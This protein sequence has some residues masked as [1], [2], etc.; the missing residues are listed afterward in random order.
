MRTLL[1]FLL[2]SAGLSL[3]AQRAQQ[4]VETLYQKFPQEKVVLSLSKNDYVAG[5]TIL[6]KAY[7]LTGYEPSDI[8]T[9]L[10]TELYDS[11]K[12]VI[13]KQ[14]IPLVKG[15]GEGS[16]VLP[17]SLAEDVYY[18]R[19]YTHYM[20]NFSEDFHYLKPLHIYNPVSLYKLTPKPAQWTA[21]AFAEGGILLNDVPGAVAIRLFST[22]GLPESWEGN[23]LEKESNTV[24]APIEFLNN[25]VGIVRFI[26]SRTKTYVA[27]IKDN[28]GNTQVVPI[29]NA[30]DN[31]TML[32]L[33]VTDTKIVYAIQTKNVAAKGAGYQLIGTMHDQ[34]IFS[35]LIKK[36][37]GDVSGEI[38]IAKL[39]SGVLRVT[40]FNEQEKPLNERLCFLHQQIKLQ[41]PTIATDTLSFQ[42]KGHNYWQIATDSISWLS[43]AVQISD[44]SYPVTNNFLSDLYLSSDFTA[45]IHQASWYLTEVNERKKIALDALLITGKWQRFRWSDILENRF[46]AIS[47]QPEKYL[48]YTGA[49]F[50]GKKL[51][52]LREMNLVLQAKDSSIQF[53]QFK[54]DSTGRFRLDNMIFLD[55]LKVYY[56]ANNRKFFESEVQINFELQNKFRPLTK[57]LPSPAFQLTKRPDDD[58]LPA[59]IKWTMAQRA[60]EMLAGEKEKTLEEVVIRTRARKETEELDKQL[61]S[62]LFSSAD[63]MIFDFVNEN[64]TAA[65]GYTNILQWLEGRVPGYQTSNVNGELVPFLRGAPT[66]IYLDEMP[67]E[68]G[69]LAGFS[70]SDIAMIKVIRGIFLGGRGGGNGAIAIYTK[71][72]GMNQK[73]LTPSLPNN[74]LVGYSK[75]LP[76]FSPDYSGSAPAVS[77][78]RQILFRSTALYP[79]VNSIQA[80]IQFYNSDRAKQYRILVTGFTS[81][82]EVVFADKLIQ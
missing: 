50:K 62:G 31:G 33:R 81:N 60:N 35:A 40:L 72:G 20:L 66:Q 11:R 63:A 45:P 67:V 44:A 12:Q 57:N 25:E 1:L 76:L 22:A 80:P 28:L 42:S 79:T 41:P 21:T 53:L 14:M 43:Y 29:P 54:S 46:P 82:G 61:S 64:Q 58:S 3:F 5:E 51:Q 38:D 78:Q 6:F 7:V 74:I 34:V 59:H 15:S 37:D 18:I 17:A 13:A 75:P 4:A 8:S 19:A 52:P 70:A 73:F 71:R 56:Q 48:S 27:S 16:F 2:L 49:V 23:L 39:P 69:L 24:V 30:A 68:A 55:T 47:Y 77:D 26:P 36:S 32:Q 65:L 9:N 10:Y